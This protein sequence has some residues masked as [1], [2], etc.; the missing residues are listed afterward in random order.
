MKVSII[1][2][3]NVGRA[4]LRC[5]ISVAGIDE[6]ALVSR[7]SNRADGEV[8][9]LNHAL[10]FLGHRRVLLSGGGRDLL[11]D[12]S[13]VVIT[14]GVP[15]AGDI[16]TAEKLAVANKDIIMECASN[17]IH[18]CGDAKVIV[19]TNPV[20][21]MAHTLL[22][23]S[24]FPPAN[25]I[26]TGTLNDTSRLIYFLATALNLEYDVIE[27]S[28]LG[29]HVTCNFIPE[30]M[31]KFKE[32]APATYFDSSKTAAMLFARAH[33]YINESAFKILE[34]KGNSCHS[35][36]AAV[37]RIV[38][39]IVSDENCILPVAALAEGEYGIEGLT[40][41]LPCRINSCG[42]ASIEEFALDG[43]DLLRLQEAAVSIWKKL[44]LIF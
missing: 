37:R 2:C 14:S 29:E 38:Q 32:L 42:I 21:V 12:S 6:I 11:A 34:G 18:Y 41:S 39:A 7:D 1:G 44:S 20:E 31:C 26:G 43:P 28:V 22:K 24:G 40:V 17:I 25:V 35:V 8:Q 36:A 33:K 9:D 30:S 10:P 15:L 23:S 4:V 3:G 5:L 13:I 19:A 16:N 27:A